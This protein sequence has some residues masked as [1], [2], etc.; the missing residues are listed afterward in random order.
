MG[1][2]DG[3]PHLLQDPG[4]AVSDGRSGRQ[5]QV[6]DAEGSIQPPGGLG[7][8]HLAH[9]GDLESRLFDGLRHHVKG[10]VLAGPQGVVYHAGA[11][12]AHIDDAVG[13]TYAV[14]SP[15][16][17][18]VI[19]HGVAEHHQLGAAQPVGVTG[20]MGR[21]L[22]DA[23]HAGHGV[24]V[25]ARLGGA[26]IDAGAD[27]I[28][29]R[30]C[31]WNGPQ[32]QLVAVGKALL[33]QRRVAADEVHAAGLGGPVHGV[34]K[35]NVVLRVAAAGHQRH[36]GHGDALVDDGNTELP[37]NLLARPHQMLRPTADLVI[38]FLAAALGIL[39]DAV[40][41]GDTHGDGADIQMAL[42][43]HVDGIKNVMYTQHGSPSYSLCIASKMS[44]L[45]IR[46]DR[47]RASP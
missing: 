46:R 38:D 41:Q 23:A 36:G 33:H 44:S 32:Q 42:I 43:D 6:Y 4:H 47:S 1:A 22:D 3:Q 17:K 7:G 19:L 24:H 21:L 20:Q 28:R 18:G 13:L 27:D 34:G 25:D 31:L 11:G 5:R 29:L 40:Q 35:G 14:E 12:D 37:L 16:H 8:H 39:A 15:G 30:Q 10:L 2:A 45:W 26:H 9:T